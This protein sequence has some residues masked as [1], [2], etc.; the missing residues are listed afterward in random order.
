MHLD[1]LAWATP[2]LDEAVAKVELLSGIR[3]AP[4]GSHPGMGTRNALLSLG[5]S[6]YLA[7]D[8]PDPA[9]PHIGNNGAVMAALTAPQLSVFVMATDAVEEKRAVLDRFMFAPTLKRLSRKRPNGAEI[10]WFA[11]EAQRHPFGVAMP[12]ITQWI[13]SDHP[14]DDAPGG[15]NLVQFEVHTPDVQT[16]SAVYEALGI[17]MPIVS[18]STTRLIAH[19]CGLNGPFFLE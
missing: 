17:G 9:Q 16:L 12:V 4:G 5:P 14:S 2:S 15:C 6:M 13:T 7:I 19:L 1:H 11:L 8:G 10:E 3:A 18:G